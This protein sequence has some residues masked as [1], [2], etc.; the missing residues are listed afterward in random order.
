[1]W[2]CDGDVFITMV[3]EMN[4]VNLRVGIMQEG[5]IVTRVFPSTASDG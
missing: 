4:F 2:R 5:K 3:T 1:M